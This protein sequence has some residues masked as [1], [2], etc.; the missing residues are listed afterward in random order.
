MHSVSV[1]VVG[2]RNNGI[3]YKIDRKLAVRKDGLL[4]DEVS[5]CTKTII[6]QSLYS[7]KK[8]IFLKK[9]IF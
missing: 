4:S 8:F 5:V 1:L 2:S 7:S 3:L 6:F 9:S